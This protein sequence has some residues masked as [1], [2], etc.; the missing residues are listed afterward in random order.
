MDIENNAIEFIYPQ[1]G[2]P[3]WVDSLSI[4]RAAPNKAAAYQFLNFLLRPDV[5]AAIMKSEYLPTPITS[6]FAKLPADLQQSRML[7]PLDSTLARGTFL[8]EVSPETM[9]LFERYWQRLR[10]S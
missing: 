2:Y 7:F 1:D 8:L 4:T 5:S 10:I 9:A 6:A 3:L